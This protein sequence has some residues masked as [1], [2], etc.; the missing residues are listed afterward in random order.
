MRKAP[1][2]SLRNSL[3]TLRR[4]GNNRDIRIFH[5]LS[6]T[7]DEIGVILLFD[8]RDFGVCEKCFQ[9]VFAFFPFCRGEPVVEFGGEALADIDWFG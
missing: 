3:D 1:P 9:R 7:G 2:R 5:T 4:H 6:K 8:A